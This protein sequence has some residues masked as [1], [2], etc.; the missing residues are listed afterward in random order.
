MSLMV[1]PLFT[2]K[3]RSGAVGFPTWKVKN[4]YFHFKTSTVCVPDYMKK[5]QTHMTKYIS[6]KDIATF[7]EVV[8][9]VDLIKKQTVTIIPNHSSHSLM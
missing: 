8:K 6:S 4:K 1:L 2:F 3:N 7:E 9:T 5:N